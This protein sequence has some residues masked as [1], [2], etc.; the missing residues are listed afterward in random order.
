VEP[1]KD[2]AGL[3]RC[4]VLLPAG[5][6]LADHLVLSWRSPAQ[7]SWGFAA[8]LYLLLVGQVAAFSWIAG[9]RIAQPLIRW[10]VFGW[11]LVLV[12]L[13]V[14][15]LLMIHSFG[16]PLH[17]LGFAL[18]SAEVGFLGLW[19]ILGTHPWPW[20]LPGAG[21]A[22]AVLVFFGLALTGP[23]RAGFGS[24]YSEWFLILLVQGPVVVALGLLLRFAGYRMARL[25]QPGASGSDAEGLGPFQFGI[26]HM[27]FWTTL[28]VPVVLLAKSLSAM[29]WGW[30]GRP[31]ALP[32]VTLGV[33]Q[34]VVSLVA[35]WSALG[36]GRA[37]LRLL[38]LALAAP[39]V[40]TA[41]YGWALRVSLSATSSP[42]TAGFP[43]FAHSLVAHVGPTWIGFT[44]LAG[45]FLA[46]MLLFFRADGYR[47]IRR[48]RRRPRATPED[49]PPA[50]PPAA[51]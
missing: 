51:P 47:L 16:N 31:E 11:V 18:I 4:A 32:V 27:L 36:K 43:T 41:L 1:A 23:P 20:R 24:A 34:G 38:V 44:A 35:T 49:S 50:L 39:A 10:V 26:G 42:R 7:W 6:V 28:A 37:R 15:R 14:F 30:F 29:G 48:P 5:L 21:A 40:G 9:R 25:P 2:Y 19:A 45:G 3:L 17:A 46:G 8:G 12:D 33:A 13:L 22:A